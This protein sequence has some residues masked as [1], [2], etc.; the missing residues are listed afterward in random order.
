MASM[1][2]ITSIEDVLQNFHDNAEHGQRAVA[3]DTDEMW[4]WKNDDDTKTIIGAAQ[5]WTVDGSTFAG[6]Y[7]LDF[8]EVTL[9]DDLL[10]DEYIK[11]SSVT[12]NLI[13]FE[14]NK[15]TIQ[16][17]GVINALFEDNL[18]TFVLDTTIGGNVGIGITNPSHLLHIVKDHA[19]ATECRIQN[20][21]NH[22]SAYAAFTAVS[23]GSNVVQIAAYPP[24][25]TTARYQD[26]ALLYSGSNSGMVI[27][28]SDAFPI[29]FWTNATKRMTIDSA[30]AIEAPNGNLSSGAVS[31]DDD[32][33]TSF[34][35]SCLHGFIAIGCQTSCISALICYDCDGALSIQITSQSG[36]SFVVGTVAL[37][38]ET[39]TG[40]D[41][42]FN[43]N[44]YNGQIYLKNRL[45]GT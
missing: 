28:Q 9:H 38:S 25:F 26:K 4:L 8:G 42:K 29:D 19:S 35:P 15:I 39:T 7:N 18:I 30:G 34:T 40:T 6:Y 32:E 13:R 16:S 41:G 33:A 43:V 24:L 21:T 2:H 31:L 17:G 23:Q 36:T 5:G 11:L 12:D 3:T 14:D 27:E 20:E 44:V 22:A 37:G 1:Y 10:V 45:G